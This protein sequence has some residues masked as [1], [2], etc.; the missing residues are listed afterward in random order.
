ML[1]YVCVLFSSR[2]R[3]TRCALVT[4]VQTCALPILPVCASSKR[5]STR[6]RTNPSCGRSSAAAV[7]TSR[8]R[9]RRRRR[10]RRRPCSRV[11]EGQGRVA[12]EGRARGAL[13]SEEH[14]SELQSL[15]RHSYSV[16][17]L[18]K[19]RHIIEHEMK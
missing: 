17:T 19:K 7:S 1:N 18:Q 11:P 13:R 12:E 14:T 9:G 2:R 4:G 16:L 6:K 8:C 3:H 10:R 5:Y 15:M